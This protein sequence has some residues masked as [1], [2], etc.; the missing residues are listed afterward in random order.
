MSINIIF[1]KTNKV[2]KHNGMVLIINRAGKW[3]K[4]S[5]EVYEI[6]RFAESKNMDMEMLVLCMEREDDKKIHRRFLY[7]TI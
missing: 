2:I 5:E 3:V 1:N 4:M 6:L 7:R